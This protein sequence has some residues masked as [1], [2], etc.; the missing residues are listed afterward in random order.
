MPQKTR[1]PAGFAPAR[2]KGLSGYFLCCVRKDG[3]G[4]SCIETTQLENS[5]GYTLSQRA[6]V[7]SSFNDFCARSE[8]FVD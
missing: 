8:S 5:A 4:V 7:L 6:N 3:A 2:P 1:T